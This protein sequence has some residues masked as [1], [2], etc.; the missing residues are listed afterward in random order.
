M[1]VNIEE[2]AWKRLY[3][4]A[5]NRRLSIREVVGT[6]ACLWSNSQDRKRTHAT[7]EEIIQWAE[8]SELSENICEMWITALEYVGF[9]LHVDNSNYEIRGNKKQL[10]KIEAFIK[11]ASKGG[12]ALKKKRNASSMLKAGL[13]E[14]ASTL[15]AGYK[16]AFQFNSIH[17]NT[18]HFNSSHSEADVEN[19][20]SN[21]VFKFLDGFDKEDGAMDS[22]LVRAAVTQIHDTLY[23]RPSQA[24]L[25]T[26]ADVMAGEEWSFDGMKWFLF[27]VL[28]YREYCEKNRVNKIY[29][30]KKFAVGW[31][32]WLPVE[33]AGVQ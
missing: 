17:Y 11:R 2:E 5:Y 1:R 3:Q 28:R 8:L 21:P 15:R 25:K 13:K 4:M 22:N 27:A 30:F 19:F 10:E 26:V 12:K 7:K 16:S 29:G 23:P 31:T 14:D 9:I 32:D 24:A 6:L 33:T 18:L 20:C